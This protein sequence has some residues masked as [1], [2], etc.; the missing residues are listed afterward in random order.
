MRIRRPC[1][2]K[3][4]T[5]DFSFLSKNVG[6]GERGSSD[7]DHQRRRRRVEL[8]LGRAVLV[9]FV[10][11]QDFRV[12]VLHASRRKKRGKN[13]REPVRRQGIYFSSSDAHYQHEK[14]PRKKLVPFAIS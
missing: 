8:Q 3:Q 12:H 2:H 6:K 5:N 14:L 7:L 11:H 10:A 4:F 13:S 9:P 1:F